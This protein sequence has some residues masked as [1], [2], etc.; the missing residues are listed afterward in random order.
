MSQKQLRGYLRSSLLTAILFFSA[1]SSWSQAIY[2]PI[3][4]HR[5]YADA[6][7]LAGIYNQFK[8]PHPGL[9]DT[10]FYRKFIKIMMTYNPD[11]ARYL[12]PHDSTCDLNV[13]LNGYI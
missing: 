1:L 4:V 5:T 9:A 3:A 11:Y 6:L 7:T 10:S 8:A 13:L 12:T 2:K